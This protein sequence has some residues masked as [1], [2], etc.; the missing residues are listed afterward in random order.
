MR[1]A[2]G[3]VQKAMLFLSVAELPNM[4]RKAAARLAKDMSKAPTEDKD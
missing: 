3:D 1:E 4:L 2:E